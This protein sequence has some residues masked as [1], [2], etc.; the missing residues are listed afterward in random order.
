MPVDGTDGGPP[1]TAVP[2]VGAESSPAGDLPS[3][4]ADVPP[5][6]SEVETF[7]TP[8]TR[9]EV[10]V[11]RGIVQP[12]RETSVRAAVAGKLK[13]LAVEELGSITEGERI[14]LV[15]PAE[16]VSEVKRLGLVAQGIEHSIQETR[17]LYSAALADAKRKKYL[18][19]KRVVSEKEYQDAYYQ[20]KSLHERLASLA[21]QLQA[22]HQAEET[23][24][25][26]LTKYVATAPFAGIVSRVVRLPG[27]FV[28]AADDIVW[29]ESHDKQIRVILPD[30]LVTHLSQ[31]TFAVEIGDRQVDAPAALV[32]QVDG[33]YC[34]LLDV[35]TR[36]ELL[37]GEFVDVRVRR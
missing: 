3:L 29:I 6:R 18:S 27:E 17:A 21:A 10:H 20:A 5:S 25:S 26:S 22:A 30:D 28:D 36:P 31:L 15:D 12:R 2:A 7:P 37:T 34:V 1:P 8:V 11:L 14:A 23:T 4:L 13:D 9:D 19:D 35:G 24:R 33:C 16:A 32:P